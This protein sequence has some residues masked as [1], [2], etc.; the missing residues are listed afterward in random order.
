ME[1]ETNI[2]SPSPKVHHIF[3]NSSPSSPVDT[4]RWC[5]RLYKKYPMEGLTLDELM[6]KHFPNSKVRE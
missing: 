6:Q 3:C 5:S 2:P 1:N 4:C